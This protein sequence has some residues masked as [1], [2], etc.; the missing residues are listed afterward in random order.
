MVQRGD[1]L[2]LG[3]CP[4]GFGTWLRLTLLGGL[5]PYNIRVHMVHAY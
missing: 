5:D 3:Q 1:Y 2:V 4:N